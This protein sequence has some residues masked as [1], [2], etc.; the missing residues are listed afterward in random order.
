MIVPKDIN[1]DQELHENKYKKL[2]TTHTPTHT[3]KSNRPDIT[4]GSQH[5][6]IINTSSLIIC[7]GSDLFGQSSQP[8][9]N[10]TSNTNI[11]I[12]IN[13]NTKSNPIS[14]NSPK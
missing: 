14:N 10:P 6:C 2:K 11:Y 4:C 1:N 8:T 3:S 12:N 9:P 7:F 5:T 13:T